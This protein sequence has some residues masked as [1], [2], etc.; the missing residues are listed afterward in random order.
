LRFVPEFIVTDYYADMNCAQ[1]VASFDYRIRLAPPAHQEPFVRT[2]TV[3][4]TNYNEWPFKDVPVGARLYPSLSDPLSAVRFREF[5]TAGTARPVVK[6]EPVLIAD[7]G[8]DAD[9]K[10]PLDSDEI[11]VE[12]D[13]RGSTS[14]DSRIARYEWQVDYQTLAEGERAVLNLP[15]G[16]HVVHL[17]VTDGK[18][19]RSRDTAFVKVGWDTTGLVN[20]ALK[21]NGG[22]ATANLSHCD[23]DPGNAIDGVLEGDMS[24]SW[25]SE[26]AS[27]AWWQVDLGEPRDLAFVV[28][29]FRSDFHRAVQA[30][31]FEILAS[32]DPGFGTYEVIAGRAAGE[33]FPER[34]LWKAEVDADRE[35]R[36][37][38]LSKNT[39]A[40]TSLHEIEVYCRESGRFFEPQPEQESVSP[41]KPRKGTLAR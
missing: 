37:V 17:V 5:L 21:E 38:R 40:H 23:L 19:R 30:A 20:Y 25:T 34:S 16:D 29:Y 12:M 39:D 6:P 28:I 33:P 2:I 4:R 14:M 32:N 27:R 7:A 9:V 10:M 3:Y 15:Y 26:P 11:Q 24:D 8:P 35:Y 13:G 36:Y 18:G 1:P 41:C 31:G 22:V